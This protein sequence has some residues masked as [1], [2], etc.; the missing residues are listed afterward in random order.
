MVKDAYKQQIDWWYIG[1]QMTRQKDTHSII[2]SHLC[3]LYLCWVIYTYLYPYL[4][5]VKICIHMHINI[6]VYVYVDKNS[7][8]K[9]RRKRGNFTWSKLRVITQETDSQKALSNVPL[10]ISQT[11]HHSTFL[12]QEV[13][14]Q[15]DILIFYVK[16]HLGYTVQARAYKV[17]SKSPWPPQSW[18]RILFI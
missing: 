12:R 7:I 16:V 14:Y 6:H 4:N 13:V 2:Y 1:T 9:L 3:C 8:N 10:A 11:H 15:N 17:G 5:H 18:E